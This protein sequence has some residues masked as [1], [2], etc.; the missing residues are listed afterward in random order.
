MLPH[1]QY[2]LITGEMRQENH[3]PFLGSKEAE[4]NVT[5]VMEDVKFVHFSDWPFP[6][7]WLKASEEQ[8]KE[9]TPKSEKERDVW[10]G[11]YK[12]FS[13]RREVCHGFLILKSI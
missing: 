13:E 5:R 10:A 11:I 2:D 8:W 1:R 7:P 9:A 6:K 4:W 3:A 12:D